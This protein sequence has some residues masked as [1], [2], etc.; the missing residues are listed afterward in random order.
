[1][2]VKKDLRSISSPKGKLSS[3]TIGLYCKIMLQRLMGKEDISKIKS[4]Q[5]LNHQ[6]NTLKISQG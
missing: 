1:M 3:E 2:Q 5:K 6:T 4:T